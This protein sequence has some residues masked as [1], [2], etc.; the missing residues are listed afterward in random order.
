MP[1]TSLGSMSLVNWTRWNVQ[2]RLRARAWARV[3]LPTPGTSS[4]Q[5][6]PARQQS[7]EREV[8][9][10]AVAANHSAQRLLELFER[11]PKIL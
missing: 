5:K 7:R 9:R 1:I 10:L 4:D 8:H 2:F 3:V 6:M 11:P